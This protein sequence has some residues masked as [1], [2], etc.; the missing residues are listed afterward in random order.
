MPDAFRHRRG[1]QQGV[2]LCGNG[3]HYEI[4]FIGESHVEHAVR[5]VQNDLF[6]LREIEVASG[7]HVLEP[8]GGPHHYVGSIAQTAGLLPYARPAVDGD[9]PVP[10]VLGQLVHLLTYLNGE[11]PGGC[12]N[13]GARLPGPGACA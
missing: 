10:G 12:E 3:I 13:E 8:A 4:Q 2:P 1:E 9:G 6:Y 11:L 7:D 5:L